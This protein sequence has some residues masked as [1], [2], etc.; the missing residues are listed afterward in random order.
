MLL[1]LLTLTTVLIGGWVCAAMNLAWI[2][3]ARKSAQP[4]VF[5]TSQISLWSLVFFLFF[6]SNLAPSSPSPSVQPQKLD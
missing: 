4:S 5:P 2:G 3:D 1:P 6:P